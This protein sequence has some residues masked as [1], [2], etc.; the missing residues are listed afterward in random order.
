MY[1]VRI[2]RD[3]SN[4][5]TGVSEECAFT[6][7][8][9]QNLA[10]RIVVLPV[11]DDIR[12]SFLSHFLLFSFDPRA[13]RYTHGFPIR[14][15]NCVW[16]LAEWCILIDTL[17]AR[18]KSHVCGAWPRKIKVVVDGHSST[19][20]AVGIPVYGRFGQTSPIKTIPF[21]VFII[22]VMFDD[23]LVRKQNLIWVATR[24][25]EILWIQIIGKYSIR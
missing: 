17:E 19:L 23:E 3:K 4:W 5:M 12:K 18:N 2:E 20:Y 10:I 22:Q 11:C 25:D 15:V 13:Y 8:A 14:F 7:A 6:K 1:I 9:V 21:E 16:R 24:F